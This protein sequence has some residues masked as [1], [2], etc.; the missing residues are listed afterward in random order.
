[1]VASIMTSF[2][3]ITQVVAR[4]WY[5]PVSQEEGITVPEEVKDYS[6]QQVNDKLPKILQE[7][8]CFCCCKEVVAFYQNALI[9]FTS[10][11]RSAFIVIRL[12]KSNNHL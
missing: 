4:K 12:N 2:K 6:A 3:I 7:S 5:L 1:M 9:S 10:K 8:S 11:P